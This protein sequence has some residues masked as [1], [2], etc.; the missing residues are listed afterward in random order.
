MRDKQKVRFR[1]GSPVASWLDI[2]PDAVG[3]VT[4]RYRVLRE[5]ETAPGRLDVRFGER[6]FAWAVPEQEFEEIRHSNGA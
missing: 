4:C 5:G 3:T 6:R 2:T 1:P